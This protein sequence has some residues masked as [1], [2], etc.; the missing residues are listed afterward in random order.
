LT[1]SMTCLVIR[2]PHDPIPACLSERGSLYRILLSDARTTMEDLNAP[3]RLH[4]ARR[5]TA[6]GS[7]FSF[8]WT[9]SRRQLS[10]ELNGDA[11]KA[12]RR[13]GEML[14]SNEQVTG[15]VASRGVK[16]ECHP[17][18]A[19]QRGAFATVFYGI[20]Q[21]EGEGSRLVGHFQI[22]PVGRLFV[23][24]WILLSTLLALALLLAGALRATPE[25]TAQDALPFLFPVLLPFLGLGL[26]HWL[27]RRGRPDEAAIRGWLDSLRN[28]H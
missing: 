2:K 11:D 15:R 19:R 4:L 21:D 20:V 12:A 7:V 18:S 23:S 9:P 28:G 5:M 3:A 22:H 14:A 8:L 6:Q 26:A 10:L 25:S 17:S 24:A 16:I 13:F 1:C 27:R